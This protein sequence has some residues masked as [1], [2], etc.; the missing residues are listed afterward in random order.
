MMIPPP[1][2]HKL[3]TGYVVPQ[4]TSTH[5]GL[6][7][8][9]S[10]SLHKA[11]PLNVVSTVRVEQ[12]PSDSLY[13]SSREWPRLPFTAHIERPLLHRGGSASKKA[14]GRSLL[15]V[16]SSPRCYNISP[17]PQ[18]LELEKKHLC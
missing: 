12:G 6:E 3:A 14:P 11:G 5:L 15:L 17:L 18:C 9:A 10:P 1:V 16:F 13:L 8:Q 2:V 4:M 7:L